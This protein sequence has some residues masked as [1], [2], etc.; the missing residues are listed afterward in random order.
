MAAD[1]A[2]STVVFGRFFTSI[3]YYLVIPFLT[4]YLVSELGAS[5]AEA[6]LLFGIL[7]FTRRGTAIPA[8]WAS[9]RYGPAVVLVAGLAIEAGAYLVFAASATVPVWAAAAA[10][11]GFGGSLNNMGSRSILASG[12]GSAVQFSR[13]YV[14]VNAAALVGPLAGGL[15]VERDL[16]RVTFLTASALNVLFAVAVVVLLG[17]RGRATAATSRVRLA[18]M[19][20]SLRDRDFLRFCIATL[21]CW[22]MLTQLYVALPLTISGQSLSLGYVG[23]LNALNAL[24]VMAGVWFLGRRVERLTVDARLTLL[25][26]SGGVMAAGWCV[27]VAPGLPALVVAVVVVSVGEAL[28]LSVVDVLSVAFA[29]EGRTGLY[30]GTSTMSWAVGAT[31]GS[32]LSGIAFSW[33]TGAGALPAFWVA[34]G[35]IGVVSAV[36]VLA[37][38]DRFRL[39]VARLQSSRQAS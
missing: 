13:Y 4:V 12:D 21:G 14:M 26:A 24:V 9:D 19:A 29:P 35:I 5:A 11:H 17:G 22:Y 2:A 36:L 25:A 23:V 8:G 1:R 7:T 38:R 6:G 10:L 28:F 3:G 33:A 20:A 32:L 37:Q 18:E 31:A 16:V 39:A 34:L 27:C 15:L 30:L